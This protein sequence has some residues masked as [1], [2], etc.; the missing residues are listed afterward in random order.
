MVP[1]GTVVGYHEIYLTGATSGHVVIIPAWIIA[2]QPATL[3]SSTGTP[4]ASVGGST[5]GGAPSSTGGSL[6]YTGAGRGVWVTLVG[7]LLLLD[8]GYLL[9]TMFLR[10]RELLARRANR[11]MG[12][13]PNK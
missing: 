6:A 1:V 11:R 13:T 3:A 7:G 10:P 12:S 8:L 5:T 9:V 4:A 2:G